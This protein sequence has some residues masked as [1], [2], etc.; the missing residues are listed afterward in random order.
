MNMA[1]HRKRKRETVS[2]ARIIADDVD[3]DDECL[4]SMNRVR[5]MLGNCSAMHLWRLLN[6]KRYA[7]LK[8]PRP[9]TIGK[10]GSQRAAHDAAA[11]WLAEGRRVRIALPPE[12]DTDFAD[13]LVADASAAEEARHVA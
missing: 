6:D 4:V 8:F 1:A 7:E 5:E 10:V 13:L 9:V 2:R 12:P 3:H 11:R